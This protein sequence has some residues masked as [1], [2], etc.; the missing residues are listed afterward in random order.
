MIVQV[1]VSRRSSDLIDEWFL[2][3]QPACSDVYNI[4][5]QA[6]EEPGVQRTH[7]LQ[8]IQAWVQAELGASFVE[9]V[10][11]ILAR[12]RLDRGPTCRGVDDYHVRSHDSGIQSEALQPG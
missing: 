2:I 1:R 4:G 9:D 6:V 10:T 11:E 7:L 3:D 8:P 12:G 5:Q